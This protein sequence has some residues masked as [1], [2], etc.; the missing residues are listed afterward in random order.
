[1]LRAAELTSAEANAHRLL[2]RGLIKLAIVAVL[3]AIG[4][5]PVVTVKAMESPSRAYWW[6]RRR[7]FATQ[8]WWD[9]DD[10]LLGFRRR[11]PL[12]GCI[13]DLEPHEI[14]VVDKD[15]HG[16]TTVY[17]AWIKEFSEVDVRDR[18]REISRPVSTEESRRG[19]SSRG[20]DSVHVDR[21]RLF[22]F[23]RGV[24]GWNLPYPEDV[25]D[26]QQEMRVPHPLAG[27]IIPRNDETYW[28]IPERI[29]DQIQ[30][31]INA[32]N[33]PAEIPEERDE[34]GNVIQ[35]E[36]H[37]PLVSSSDDR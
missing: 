9:L 2:L 34:E 21:I 4:I 14:E 16:N 30:D 5:P 23:K 10:A 22:N 24:Q 1:M 26:P 33:E 11:W 8:L 29:M 3:G 6:F 36:V 20:R 7:T 28:I 13:V 25:W 15:R 32:L 27:Q 18:T 12:L 17:K 31:E 35:P 37:S 19:R